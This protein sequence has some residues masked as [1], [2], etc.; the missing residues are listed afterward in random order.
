[1][2]DARTK[3]TVLH[4]DNA[5]FTDNS[6]K[7]ADYT[8]DSFTHDLIA[9]EDYIYIGYTKPFNASYI[10][11]ETPNVNTNTLVAEIWDGSSWASVELTDGSQGF[12]RSGYIEWSKA[13]M[14][15]TTINSLARFYIRLKPSADHSS[16]VYRGINLVFSEDA[17]MKA[18]F[19]EIT[20]S[21]ILPSGESSHIT[22]H[23]AARNQIM[24]LFRKRYK[25][26]NATTG[27][28]MLNQ[29]DLHDI[30]E[31]REAA[32]FLALSKIFFNLSDSVD[33]NWW[34]KYREYNDKFE[35][36]FSQ[37]YE[38]L[39]LDDDGVVDDTEKVPNAAPFRWNR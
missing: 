7:A 36:M 14:K 13:D 22:T 32:T 3:L 38:S 24:Q 39:D 21:N 23:V 37:A 15:S 28:A 9:A 10:E 1:M 2:I 12:T 11:L 19:F 27:E 33:D 16:T 4:D 35:E 31:V 26:D 29:W 30:Y 25:K 8:R 34:Q 6:N 5:V 20:N 17:A 18:E